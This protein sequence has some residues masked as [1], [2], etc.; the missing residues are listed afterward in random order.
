MMKIVINYKYID[1]VLV[2]DLIAFNYLLKSIMNV[3]I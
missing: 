2:K 3:N 1:L